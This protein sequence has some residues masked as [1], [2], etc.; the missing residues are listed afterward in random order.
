MML[1]IP[2]VVI[3]ILCF[4]IEAMAFLV[5][6]C[7]FRRDNL[8]ALCVLYCYIPV[9][10]SL[11]LIHVFDRGVCFLTGTE[12]KV[13]ESTWHLRIVVFDYMDVDNS[14]KR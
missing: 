8:T 6:L 7:C 14:T 13:R 3:L 11:R 12:E 5:T 9:V 10:K 1:G 2:A 4:I